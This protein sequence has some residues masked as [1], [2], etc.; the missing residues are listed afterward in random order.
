MRTMTYPNRQTRSLIEQALISLLLGSAVFAAAVLL[1]ILGY[2]F[3]YANRIF[4]GVSIAGIDVGGLTPNEAA[5][6]VTQQL[7]YPLNGRLLLRSDQNSWMVTPANMG[8]YLDPEINRQERHA[9]R[10]EWRP[11]PCPDR[12]V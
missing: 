12:A 7:S 10:P 1:F 11:V 5:A 4:P 9:G 6:R 3:R 2:Q 8:L